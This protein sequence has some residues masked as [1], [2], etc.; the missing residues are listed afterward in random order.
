MTTRPLNNASFN[1]AGFLAENSQKQQFSTRIAYQTLTQTLNYG[2]LWAKT[3]KAAAFFTNEGVAPG[4]RVLFIAT[5][6]INLVVGYLGVIW[7]GGVAVAVNPRIS[8]ADM[9]KIITEAAPKM[10]LVED[11]LPAPLP[12]G[13][14]VSLMQLA[15]A[16]E[17][18]ANAK[19]IAPYPS[20]ANDPA[21][22][23]YTSGTTGGVKAVV[24]AHGDMRVADDYLRDQLA[25]TE[26]KQDKILASSR[27]FF[28]YALGIVVFGGL[29]LGQTMLLYEGFPEAKNF[30]DFMAKTK[31]SLLFSVPSFY[32]KLAGVMADSDQKYLSQIRAFISAGERLPLPI[33]QAWKNFTGKAIFDSYGTSETVLMIFANGLNEAG[34]QADSC[35]KPC[36]GVE[37]RLLDERGNLITD[38][39]QIGTLSVA[40]PSLFSH[41]W[42]NQAGTTSEN[43]KNWFITG[44][45][46]SVDAQGFWTHHGRA[47]D[48]FKIA[49]QFV[50]PAQIEAVA[51]AVDGIAEACL[52]GKPNSEGL[53]EGVLYLALASGT[54][55]ATVEAKLWEAL[56]GELM[57][58]QIPRRVVQLDALPRT[59]TGKVKRHILRMEI[60]G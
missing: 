3:A 32:R 31:P 10:I 17:N 7:A 21:F 39:Q 60:A 51:L 15:V 28:A 11:R 47:D 45:L 4:D 48:R 22:F 29:R 40:M 37:A 16:A 12:P 19:P 59:Q 8:A 2:E 33:D 54:D 52:V 49:G 42:P 46:F 5:D 41:Y 44:D 26:E 56:K 34:Y 20:T 25:V 35:G 13:L 1:I 50:S 36:R 14:G 53:L 55:F 9:T 43:G 18:W 27:L 23:V 6:Q 38:S 57:P 30:R 58:H 24:H